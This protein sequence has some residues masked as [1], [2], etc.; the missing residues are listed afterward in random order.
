MKFNEQLKAIRKQKGLTQRELADVI[1]A[2][3]S[4]ISN[5]EHGVSQPSSSI[6][7]LLA[8]ALGVSPFDLLGEFTLGDIQTLNSKP[9][10]ELPFEESTALTFANYI[11]AQGAAL[12]LDEGVFV[13][14][15]EYPDELLGIDI[16]QIERVVKSQEFNPA[17]N[18][19]LL[20]Y[21]AQDGGFEFLLAYDYLNSDG[22]AVLLDY[23]TAL[24]K[25]PLYLVEGEKGIDKEMIAKVQHLRF[26]VKEGD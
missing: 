19:Q 20:E 22:K 5:W 3:N 18:H 1:K 2:R 14:A 4:S 7:E 26:K 16:R 17:A 10:S 9:S 25:T 23:L 12:Q 11:I 24:L 13:Y 6:V 8:Q 15:S 21:L